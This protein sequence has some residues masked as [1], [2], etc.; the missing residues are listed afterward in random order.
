MALQIN[1]PCNNVLGGD[2]KGL[3]LNSTNNPKSMLKLKHG[4]GMIRVWDL[5][6]T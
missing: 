5:L 1:G 4:A 6:I 2:N 3:D